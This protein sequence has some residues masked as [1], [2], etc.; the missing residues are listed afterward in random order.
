MRIEIIYISGDYAVI[1]KPAGMLTES[2]DSDSCAAEIREYLTENSLP[3]EDVYTVHRLDRNTMGLMV[4][5]LTKKSAAELSRLIAG[6]EFH[7]TYRALIN[8]SEDLPESGEM[9]DYLFFD[10]V[11]DKS[12]VVSENK[13]SAKLAV[14]E[15]RLGETVEVDGIAAREAWIQLKTGRTHQIRVQFASRRSPLI[16]DKKYGSRVNYR[17]CALASVKIEFPWNGKTAEYEI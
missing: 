8:P 5:A 4:Y 10:R 14:L 13:K 17:G 6:G 1:N 9:R 15:Y 2:S 7:K 3:F 11:R 16:G 12:F